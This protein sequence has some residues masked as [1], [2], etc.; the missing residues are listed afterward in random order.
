MSVLMSNLN[1]IFVIDY[2]FLR[3]FVTYCHIPISIIT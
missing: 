3:D 2:N 1:S